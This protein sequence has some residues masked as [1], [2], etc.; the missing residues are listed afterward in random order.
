MEGALKN[1][2]GREAVVGQHPSTAVHAAGSATA[3]E[4]SGKCVVSGCPNGIT[5]VPVEANQETA[6][7]VRCYRW[8]GPETDLTGSN[9]LAENHLAPK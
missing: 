4:R 5:A 7:V 1:K 8:I 3:R 9:S 6:K 2:V